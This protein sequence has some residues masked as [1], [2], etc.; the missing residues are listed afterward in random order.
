M[1]SA[2]TVFLPQSMS[3]PVWFKVTNPQTWLGLESG[4]S[5]VGWSS[6]I[7]RTIILLGVVGA[8]FYFFYLVR[9]VVF[10]FLAGGIFAYFLYRPV[11]WLETKGL[12]RFWAIL[13]I[14]LFVIVAIALIMWF[15]IPT[16]MGELSHLASLLPQYEIRLQEF[17][18]RLNGMQVPGR[19]GE[20][21]AQ[22]TDKLENAIYTTLDNIVSSL[23]N[24]L[25]KAILVV[26]API[27]AFYI[28]KDWELI[29][30][31]MGSFWPPVTRREMGALI[32]K[33]DTVI[34]EFFKGYLIIACIVGL[35]IGVSAALIGI[36]YPLL[37]GVIGGIGE[38]IPYFGPFLGGIP[39]VGLA[40][41]HSLTEGLYMVT[42]LIVIQQLE[43]NIITPRLIGERVGIHPLLM[44][45]ALLAG[46][47]LMGIWGMVIAVPLAATLKIIGSYLYLKFVGD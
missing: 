3:S 16:L 23:Y 32:E 12:K 47:K 25:N 14:Y 18:D 45:F 39:A 7:I 11:I 27:M 35:L 38:M 21:I 34:M 24:L 42:A 30:H 40:L 19:T 13:S 2:K 9:D 22:Y 41:S 36:P 46:G 1:K 20:I 10:S 15:T 6:K 31:N 33:I 29:K 4:M 43:G 17:T 5:V 8:T 44:V 26:F 37:I 28:V